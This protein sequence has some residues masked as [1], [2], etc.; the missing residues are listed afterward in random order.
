MSVR[1]ALRT[2]WHSL[3][4]EQAAWLDR[5]G[6]GQA[7]WPIVLASAAALYIEMVMVRW[8]A[9]CFHA[10][11]IFKNV[12]LLSCFLGLGVGYALSGRQKI[13]LSRFLPLLALQTVLFGVLSCTN[14]GGRIVNPVAEQMVMGKDGDSWSVLHAIEGN[15]FLLVVFTLN[16]FLFVPLGQLTGRLMTGLPR[17]QAYS[18]N[19]VGS[20]LGIGAFFVLSLLWAGPEIWLGLSVVVLL[21]F[22][23]GQRRAAV[24]LAG[25]TAL[26]LVALGVVASSRE[27]TFY[28][29]YQVITYQLPVP[30]KGRTNA[31][32][33][34]NHCYYQEILNCSATGEAN[35]ANTRGALFYGLP[36]RLQ[37]EPGDVLVVGAGTGNDVAAALRHGARTVT[38]VELDPAILD[39]GRKVHP[40]RPYENPRTRAVVNDARTHLRQTEERYDTIMYGLLDS[41]TNIG[42]MTN[43]R[44]DSYVYTVE[45]FREAIQRLN[46]GGLIIVSYTVLDPSQGS[47]LYGM[48]RQAYPDA[49]PRAF[50]IPGAEHDGGKT[51]VTGPGLER[52]PAE[53]AG[54]RE[55]TTAFEYVDP[56]ELA[57]DDWPFFYMK[58]RVYPFTYLV[59]IGLMLAVSA[60]FIRGHLGSTFQ[61]SASWGLF[62]FL[63]AGFMLLETKGVTELGLIFGNT[64][65]VAAVVIASILVMGYLANRWVMRVGPMPV[66]LAFGLLFASLVLGWVVTALSV[67][68]VTIPLARLVLPG[69]LTLPLFFAGLIFSGG[70][71]R[72]QDIGSVLS[73]NILGAMLGGFLEYNSMYWGYTSLYPLGLALYGLA[74]LC[75]WRSSRGRARVLP[76]PLVRSGFLSDKRRPFG[77]QKPLNQARPDE[78]DPAARETASRCLDRVDPEVEPRA[79][80]GSGA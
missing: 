10:F 69:V 71:T 38:A 45:A 64:W 22:L 25:C 75:A 73:A 28:S 43:V 68:G 58:K 5:L 7:R 55:L 15:A 60:W 14:L 72:A 32:I 76:D 18:L 21:P 24:L 39:L 35:P 33:R 48:L 77:A 61:P 80:E 26:M 31:S 29:P 50:S 16:A 4:Q 11:A 74:A 78:E 23:A 57:T 67:S 56:W 65:S 13:G 19:L 79:E 47:K 63:G 41:H 49:A 3:D 20:L 70:L 1:A 8:H 27:L 62:F 66:G 6:Q 17:V 52:L 37:Q 9:T 44:V 2:W 12:S 42:A 34:V 51:F 53:I 46:K 54:V 59:M 30:G 36:Y 40:E